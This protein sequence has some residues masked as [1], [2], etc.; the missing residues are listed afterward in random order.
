MSR[1]KSAV[2]MKSNSFI[3]KCSHSSYQHLLSSYCHTCHTNP[4]SG[5][6]ALGPTYSL[7]RRRV[8]YDRSRHSCLTSERTHTDRSYAWKWGVC[9]NRLE[10]QRYSVWPPSGI[11]PADPCLSPHHGVKGYVAEWFGQSRNICACSPG[12]IDGWSCRRDSIDG[13]CKSWWWYGID[14]RIDSGSRYSY[15]RR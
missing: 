13:R 7:C 3:H 1:S 8:H 9:L 6:K 2:G 12:N 15:R 4:N 14:D 10:V 5:S 11:C